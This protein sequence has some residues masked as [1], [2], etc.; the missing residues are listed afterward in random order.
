MHFKLLSTVAAMMEATTTEAVGTMEGRG[1]TAARTLQLRR[2]SVPRTRRSLAPIS[3][4]PIGA[5]PRAI[6]AVG[7]M[8]RWAVVRRASRVS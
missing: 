2:L 6:P 3:I 1:I 4:S 5:V 8:A 7:I